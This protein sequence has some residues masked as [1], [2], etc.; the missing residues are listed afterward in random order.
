M[1]KKTLMAIIRENRT[2]FIVI[3]VGLF[4]IELEIFVLAAMKSGRQSVI[5]VMTS[6][7][8]VIY[9]SDGRN[10]SQFDKYYFEQNFG[11]IAQYQLKLHTREI[12]FP[13]RA[14]FV[15]AF[16][17]PV[18]GILLFAFVVKAYLSIFYGDKLKESEEALSPSADA[19]MLERFLVRISRYNIF[20]I[21]FLVLM[22]IMTYW[23]VPNF[24][25]HISQA[26]IDTLIRYKW[27]FIIAAAVSLGLLTWVIYLRYLLA[28]KSIE[29]RTELEKH[30]LELAY[31]HGQTP[32][33][34]D[35]QRDPARLVAW[36]EGDGEMPPGEKF[37]S[38]SP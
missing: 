19:S 25:V 28:R 38:Q 31:K 27:F 10:L 15:A 29:S 33:R 6:T 8:E 1:Q 11:P 2:L 36:R 12:P 20:I 17:L 5:Q 23:V 24:I 34:L 16:G 14:W 26:G 18:G 22:G 21:G 32:R 37:K 30:R 7:G 3:A 13:F 9:E 4:L 35:D